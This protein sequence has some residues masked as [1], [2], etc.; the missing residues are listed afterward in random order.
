MGVVS[1]DISHS[2]IHA[3]P[4]SM[5][6]RRVNHWFPCV[7]WACQSVGVCV[8]R[9]PV[10]GEIVSLTAGAGNGRTAVQRGSGGRA[11]A[12]PT[13]EGPLAFVRKA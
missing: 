5:V 7:G 6:H 2:L 10:E 12:A 11:A 13:A 8:G 4:W 1:V 3:G 9:L